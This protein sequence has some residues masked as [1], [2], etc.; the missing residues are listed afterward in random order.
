V[1]RAHEV[2]QVVLQLAD[3][4]DVACRPAWARLCANTCM[5]RLLADEPWISTTL[6]RVPATV[7][8]Y[9]R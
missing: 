6:P 3:V 8:A 7:G 2:L 5:L 9:A 4:V 1:A